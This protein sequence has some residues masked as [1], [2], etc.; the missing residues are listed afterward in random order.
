MEVGSEPAHPPLSRVPGQPSP[1][2]HKPEVLFRSVQEPIFPSTATSK[3]RHVTVTPMEGSVVH[4]APPRG[5][6]SVLLRQAC[7]ASGAGRR[8]QRLCSRYGTTWHAGNRSPLPDIE[9]AL[10]RMV[11]GGQAPITPQRQRPVCVRSRCGDAMCAAPQS[12]E[13]E[14]TIRVDLTVGRLA[15]S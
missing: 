14:V 5:K 9:T 1:R 6:P 12:G 7:L 15:R 13:R 2:A 11:S 8:V 3:R 10:G 4:A